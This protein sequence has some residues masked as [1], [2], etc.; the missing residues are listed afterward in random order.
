M[1]RISSTSRKQKTAG[2]LSIHIGNRLHTLRQRDSTPMWKVAERAG[3]SQAFV[4]TVE[5]GQSVAS[6]ETLWK[7]ATAFKVPV[8]YFF[9]GYCGSQPEGGRDG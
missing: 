6:A 1:G 8:G 2:P 3:L 4:C 9:E 5:N 7:L